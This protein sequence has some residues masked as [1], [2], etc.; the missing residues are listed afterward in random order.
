MHSAQLGAVRTL[1]AIAT[2]LEA[3]A[4]QSM[5]HIISEP[6]ENLDERPALCSGKA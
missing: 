5:L 1:Q 4:R 6:S 2:L 3:A